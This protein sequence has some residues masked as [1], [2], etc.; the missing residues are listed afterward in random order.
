MKKLFFLLIMILTTSA[1]A[2]SQDDSADHDAIIKACHDYFEGWYTGDGERI[3]QGLHEELAKRTVRPLPN[4]RE[5]IMPAS[6]HAMVEYANSG[7][8]KKPVEEQNIQVKIFDLKNNIASAVVMS[9]EY[10][11]Y[12][13]LAKVNGE[14]KILN[15][16]WTPNK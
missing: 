16:L 11:D 6:F 12:V 4:G 5:I 1:V 2:F 3:A 10:Y 8:G 9:K 15:V 7:L 13:H 14:W